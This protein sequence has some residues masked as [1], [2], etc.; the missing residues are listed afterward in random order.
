MSRSDAGAVNIKQ[1]VFLVLH[2]LASGATRTKN[3][4]AAFEPQ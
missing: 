3:L 2:V 1:S 4:I